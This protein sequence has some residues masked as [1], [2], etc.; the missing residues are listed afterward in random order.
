LEPD[1]ASSLACISCP[2][3]SCTSARYGQ[4]ETVLSVLSHSQLP[5]NI[6]L[7][8]L[9]VRNWLTFLVF[10]WGTVQLGMGF[11][12]NWQELLATRILLGAFEVR[13]IVRGFLA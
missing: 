5:G 4:L 3:S 7:R 12:K 8:K 10:A 2:T 1:T 11:V 6:V 13:N 9:G